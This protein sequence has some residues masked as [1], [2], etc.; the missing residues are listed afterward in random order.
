MGHSIN[1]NMQMSKATKLQKLGRKLSGDNSL[2]INQATA[3]LLEMVL[4]GE[5]DTKEPVK[6][7]KETGDKD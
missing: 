3:F 4:S 6:E 1:V 7:E 2:G 5:L